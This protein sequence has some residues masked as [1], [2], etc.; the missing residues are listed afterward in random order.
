MSWRVLKI[1]IFVWFLIGL[2]RA[3]SNKY[4]DICFVFNFSSFYFLSYNFF[5]KNIK[6]GGVHDSC[7]GFD[8]LAL[9]TRSIQYV[10]VSISFL[11]D[12]ILKKKFKVKSCFN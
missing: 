1:K 10:N 11:K 12:V 7:R 6:P 2:Y 9:M 5:K 4:C 3:V 8:E